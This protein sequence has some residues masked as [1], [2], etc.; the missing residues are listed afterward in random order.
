MHVPIRKINRNYSEMM[1][2]D[3]SS[4]PKR[5]LLGRTLLI[6]A[7]QIN[8]GELEDEHWKDKLCALVHYLVKI[9]PL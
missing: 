9:G 3:T 4:E 6:R 8:V 2:D 7:A 5:A 1:K